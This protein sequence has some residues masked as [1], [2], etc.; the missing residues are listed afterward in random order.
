MHQIIPSNSKG[1]QNESPWVRTH[2]MGD[3]TFQLQNTVLP[4]CLSEQRDRLM[5]KSGHDL[6]IFSY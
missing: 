1:I 5:A 3:V 2:E 6:G 4:Q